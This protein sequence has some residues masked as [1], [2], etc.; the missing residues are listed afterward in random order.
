MA[1][2]HT[3]LALEHTVESIQSWIVERTASLLGVKPSKISVSDRLSDFGLESVEAFTLSGELS[4]LL[5]L[6]LSPTLAWDFSTIADLAEYL[7]AEEKKSR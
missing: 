3:A 7:A 1:E 5:N 2:V 6:K 4:D